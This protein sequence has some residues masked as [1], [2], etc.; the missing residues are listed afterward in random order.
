VAALNV[1][2]IVHETR[3]S[4]DHKVF[5]N[6]SATPRLPSARPFLEKASAPEEIGK[7][8]FLNL[9]RLAENK[10]GNTIGGE[11]AA[12]NGRVFE[13]HIIVLLNVI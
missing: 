5:T 11:E 4:L 8:A 9:T 10:H 7:V 2:H 3:N 6:R 12:R 1:S 13:R